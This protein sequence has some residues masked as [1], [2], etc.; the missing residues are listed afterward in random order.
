MIKAIFTVVLLLISCRSFAECDELVA[1]I[2][3]SL[4]ITQKLNDTAFDIKSCKVKPDKPS[5]MIVAIAR[6]KEGSQFGPSAAPG[7]GLYDLDVL[8]ADRNTRAVLYRLVE[9]E[10][11]ASDAESLDSIAVDIAPYTLAREVRAFGVLVTNG[12]RGGTSSERRTLRLY[13]VADGNLKKLLGPIV[14][15]FA[16]HFDCMEYST[17]SRTI[18]LGRGSNNGLLDLVVRESREEATGTKEA[19]E[20]E[21]QSKKHVHR[22]VLRFDGK[23]YVMPPELMQ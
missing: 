23:E 15:R 12:H 2:N 17:L 18:A 1:S 19:P 7:E 11:L 3:K 9:K 22:Y 5:Q 8:V 14:T 6:Y 20:C 13:S 16:V 10:A 21:M 4:G